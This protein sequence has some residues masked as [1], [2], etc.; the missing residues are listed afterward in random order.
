MRKPDYYDFDNLPQ[1]LKDEAADREH[2]LRCNELR[3]MAIGFA[4]VG[5][6]ITLL[7]IAL[8]AFA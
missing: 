8:R 5:G 3:G 7:A 2:E 6:T 4:F 1:F